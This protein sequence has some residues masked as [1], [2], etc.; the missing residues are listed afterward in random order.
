VLRWPS[1]SSCRSADRVHRKKAATPRDFLRRIS[2][3]NGA[4][5][6]AYDVRQNGTEVGLR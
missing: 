5:P 2:K 1:G 4:G 3:G 6:V